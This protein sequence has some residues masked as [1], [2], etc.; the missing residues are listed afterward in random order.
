MNYKKLVENKTTENARL[1]AENAQL[2]KYLNDE[3]DELERRDYFGAA[4]AVKIRKFL[5]KTLEGK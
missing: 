5:H 2:I 4:K 1:R 3:A